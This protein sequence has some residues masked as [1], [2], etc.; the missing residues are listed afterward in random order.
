LPLRLITYI[1][2]FQGGTLSKFA[3]QLQSDE[4]GERGGGGAIVSGGVGAVGSSG[5][6]PEGALARAGSYLATLVQ[7]SSSSL[8]LSS[9]ELSDTKVY[10]P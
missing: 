3:K 6:G 9:L 7:P 8:L 1:P 4:R 10:E 2:S 5:A